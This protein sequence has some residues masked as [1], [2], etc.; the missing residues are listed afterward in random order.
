MAPGLGTISYV[1][2]LEQQLNATG[3]HVVALRPGYFMENLLA[4]ATTIRTQ[5]VI[6]Y[7]YAEDHDI[8]FISVADIAAVA[9]HCLLHPQWAGQ[10][11]R[12]LMGPMNLTLPTCTAL[13]AQAW[14]QPVRYQRQSTADLQQALEQGGLTAY[15]QQEMNVL[16]QAL[17]DPHG[18]YATP[19]TAE[20]YTPTSFQEFIGAHLLLLLQPDK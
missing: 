19:R 5:G 9:A 16:F 20:A 12:N 8:P 6:Q 2:E 14:G 15:A 11:A 13:L 10:W 18:A 4:Q 17:G 7:P 3:A 1:G